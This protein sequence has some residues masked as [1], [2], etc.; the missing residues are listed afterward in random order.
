MIVPRTA[1]VAG[2]VLAGAML[3]LAPHAG[4]DDQPGSS[5]GGKAVD[6]APA[7]VKLTT[8]LPAKIEVDNKTH[9]TTLTATVKNGGTKGSGAIR[10]LVVGYGGLTVNEVKG[11]SKLPAANLPAGSNSGYTCPISDLAAGGTKSYA[12][13]A[14][15]DLSK[16]GKICLPVQSPDGKKTYWQQGP[17][18]FGTTN[19]AS[20]APATPLLLGTDNK[21]AAPT[22]GQSGGA[23]LPKTG[24]S[25]DVFYLGGAGLALMSAG[26]AGVWWASRR[27]PWP[28]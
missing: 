20:N 28:A 6:A 25:E 11:C 21:P 7:D 13:S 14:T 22:G 1:V 24:A 19:S 17:V 12:V 4:A 18:P 2:S 10:L 27:R 9:K 23:E 26:A 8:T 5:L 15:Y 16:D 3:L